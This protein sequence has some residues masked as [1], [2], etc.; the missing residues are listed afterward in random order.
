MKS[1]VAVLMLFLALTC[2]A[3]I[4]RIGPFTPNPA[5]NPYYNS[6]MIGQTWNFVPTTGPPCNTIVT[7]RGMNPSNYYSQNALIMR[8]SKDQNWCYWAAPVHNAMIDF[9]LQQ[10]KPDG[11]MCSTGF[12]DYMDINTPIPSLWPCI[13]Q[14]CSIEIVP[15]QNVT[16]MPYA[17][18][19]PVGI[20]L[21]Q[22]ITIGPTAY[23]QYNDSNG[24]NW[25]NFII[26]S[27]LH[28]TNQS[29]MTNFYIDPVTGL[30][31][32]EQWE[33]A[34]GHEIWFWKNNV[35]LVRRES[36]NDGP[37]PGNDPN[38]AGLFVPTMVRTN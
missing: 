2:N 1:C 8:I 10:C 35:G 11:T 3:Q 25:N 13:A 6:G 22:T 27:Q 4:R 14:I 26:P 12:I 33:A 19:P 31:V 32:S 18:V 21:G 23:D 36:P 16:D 29:W 30:T 7:T 37:P 20:Q 5:V 34:C 38:C 28:A 15:S 24:I 9:V 17:I